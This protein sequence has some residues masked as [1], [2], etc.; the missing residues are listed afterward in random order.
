M[1]RASRHAGCSAKASE[2][3][4]SP[5]RKRSSCSL[6]S[7]TSARTGSRGAR[8][9]TWRGISA[10]PASGSGKRNF[11]SWHAGCSSSTKRV[12]LGARRGSGSGTFERWNLSSH[13]TG[14]SRRTCQVS[15]AS[16]MLSTCRPTW[17]E[18]K[19][20]Y[21]GRSAHVHRFRL[22]RPAHRPERAFPSSRSIIVPSSRIGPLAARCPC[23][24]QAQ[25]DLT[26]G[27]RQQIP[28]HLTTQRGRV[29][30]RLM[31]TSWQDA[32]PRLLAIRPRDG[33]AGY[34]REFSTRAGG[35]A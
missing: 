29:Y 24:E 3:T 27:A 34:Q 35:A 12:G 33:W 31:T 19:D 18:G 2:R 11:V 30:Y 26:L 1:W 21:V 16:R 5:R 7:T 23:G 4:T 28:A 10:S 32:R 13:L 22:A 20:T 9:G 14:W 25:G 17:P 15:P 6:C 8:N